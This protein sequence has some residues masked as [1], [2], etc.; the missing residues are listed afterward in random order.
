MNGI[1]TIEPFISREESDTFGARTLLH[2][3]QRTKGIDLTR[4]KMSSLHPIYHVIRHLTDLG[5]SRRPSVR[6]L[7]PLT[8]NMVGEEW[9]MEVGRHGFTVSALCV[10]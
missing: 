7:L 5:I 8:L 9:K 6:R 3:L 1:Y 2:S 4:C 10:G